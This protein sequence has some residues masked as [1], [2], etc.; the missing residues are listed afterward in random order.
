MNYH[1]SPSLTENKKGPRHVTLEIQLLAWNRNKN[2]SGL[3][4]LMG[5]QPSPVDNWISLNSYR[6]ALYNNAIHDNN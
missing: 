4:W 3:Y 6:S 2:V 1:F 5:S